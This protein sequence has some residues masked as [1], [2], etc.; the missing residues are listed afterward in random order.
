M[1]NPGAYGENIDGIPLSGDMSELFGSAAPNRENSELFS[2][3]EGED[4]EEFVVDYVT[5]ECQRSD[6]W[7]KTESKDDL[8]WS[9]GLEDEANL[10][11]EVSFAQ[12]D[13]ISEEDVLPETQPLHEEGLIDD[14]EAGISNIQLLNPD[15]VQYGLE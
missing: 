4:D 7:E 10:V 13:E 8:S 9:E 5:A 3:P 11:G 6:D 12:L 14:T 15:N 2:N 1:T